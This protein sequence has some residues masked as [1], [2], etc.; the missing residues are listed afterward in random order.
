MSEEAA[1]QISI[2]NLSG[3][4]VLQQNTGMLPLGYNEI[5]LDLSSVPN[6]SYFLTLLSTDRVLTLPLIVSKED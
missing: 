6:G 5:T 2:Q 4:I 3:E 1:V